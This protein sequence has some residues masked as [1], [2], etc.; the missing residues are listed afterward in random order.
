NFTCLG[1]PAKE[2]CHADEEE[3]GAERDEESVPARAADPDEHRGGGEGHD[4][5]SSHR[6]QLT[7]TDPL[8]IA[9][10]FARSQSPSAFPM[11]TDPFRCL[12]ET[13]LL[14]SPVSGR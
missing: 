13:Q 7:G 10:G 4:R 12:T 11:G 9:V 14:D 2:R 8:T 3:S 6:P 1:P 5:N